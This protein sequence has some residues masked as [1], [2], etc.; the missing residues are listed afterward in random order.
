MPPAPVITLIDLSS[1]D[2]KSMMLV[3]E[4]DP[5]VKTISCSLNTTADCSKSIYEVTVSGG[6]TPSL[7]HLT[8]AF[9]NTITF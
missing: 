1:I 8:S 9:S 3:L 6:A 2:G 4:T 5:L 7:I